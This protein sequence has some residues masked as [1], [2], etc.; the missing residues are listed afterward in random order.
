MEIK[1]INHIA[2]AVE[3]IEKATEFWRDKLG[4]DLHH[5]EEVPS[6][7]VKVASFPCGDSEVELVEPTDEN[8]GTAKFLKSRGP[9][10]HHLCLEVEDIESAMQELMAKEVRLLS[11]EPIELPDRKMAFIH[12]KSSGGVL[13][14]LYEVK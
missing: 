10:I 4:L 14:E 6:Q 2:I 3:N 5:V 1:K 7:K 13:L 8:T 12:P 9:G 11:D